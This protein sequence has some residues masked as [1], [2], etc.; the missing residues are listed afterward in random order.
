MQG[1][2]SET[3]LPIYRR[4][5]VRIQISQIGSISWQKSPKITLVKCQ[6]K[7]GSRIV[8]HYLSNVFLSIIDINTIYIYYI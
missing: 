1:I 6:M 3:N 2:A 8:S 5:T 7:V 4:V